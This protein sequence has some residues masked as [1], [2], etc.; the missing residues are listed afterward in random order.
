MILLRLQKLCR[1]GHPFRWRCWP[2]QITGTFPSKLRVVETTIERNL[3][4]RPL[5]RGMGNLPS[6][7]IQLTGPTHPDGVIKLM[8]KAVKLLKVP[9]IILTISDKRAYI[10]LYLS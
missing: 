2:G 3:V 4:V 5:G 6:P 8:T 1:L 9:K 10:T 7:K